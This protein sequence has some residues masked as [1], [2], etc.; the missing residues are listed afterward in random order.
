MN[1]HKFRKKVAI[2][3]PCISDPLCSDG[4]GMF[5]LDLAHA[6][7]NEGHM[8]SIFYISANR[9]DLELIDELRGKYASQAIL[10]EQISEPEGLVINASWYPRSSYIVYLYI[11]SMSFDVIHYPEW[12]GLGYY[13]LL[14]KHQGIAFQETTIVVNIHCPTL[15]STINNGELVNE[16]SLLERDYMESQSVALADVAMS[17]TQYILEWVTEQGWQ[18]PEN[19]QIYT[20]TLRD[21]CEGKNEYKVRE[22][23]EL[24]Y[25]GCLDIRRG[26]VLFCDALDRLGKLTD[27]GFPFKVTF[28]GKGSNVHGMTSKKYI[29]QRAK[30]WPFA[31][32]VRSQYSHRESVNYLKKTGRLAVIPSLAENYPYTVMECLRCGIPFLASCVGG[33]QELLADRSSDNLCFEPNP[34]SLAIRL[35]KCIQ[36][37]IDLAITAI[38]CDADKSPWVRL[39]ESLNHA[40]DNS[41]LVKDKEFVR[42]LVSVCLVHFDR[43]ELRKYI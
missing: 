10:W 20:D 34:K 9:E 32:E 36:E 28:L 24:V 16:L 39:N 18:L 26:L 31:W 38:D 12:S 15:W 22:V 37:G 25:F 5:Y 14:A 23:K 27:T 29:N 30:S 3:L 35:R 8:V 17:P 4:L 7:S 6:L 43:P 33:V 41:N 19:L 11:K 2:V 21:D 1:H 42:P 40:D 13:T